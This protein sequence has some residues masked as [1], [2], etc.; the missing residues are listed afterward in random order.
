MPWQGVSAVDLRLQFIADVQT[1][2]FTITELAERYHVSRKTAYKWIALARQHGTARLHDASRRPQ[3]SPTRTPVAIVRRLCE[4]RQR[5]PHWSARKL[6]I[7]LRRQDPTTA[8]PCA[9][10]AH[11]WL[12]REGW[13][14]QKPRRRPPLYPPV[15]LTP[16]TRPNA[17]W[18][19]D[20]KG[21]LRLGAGGW[22]Y[23]L[24]LRDAASRFVLRCVALT[25]RATGVTQPQFERAFREFGL[26][27]RIRSDN[28]TP[29]ASPGLARLSRLAVW[30][31]RLGI[32]PERITPGRPDQNGAHEQF[33]RVLKRATALPPAASLRAQQRRFN[34]FVPEYNE[35]RPHDALAGDPPARHYVPST[36]PYP[37]RLPPLEYPAAWPTR[38]VSINGTFSWR[39][40]PIRLTEALAG[41]HIAFEEV[42]D[43]LWC[44]HFATVAIVRFDDRTRSLLPLGPC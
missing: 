32:V 4:A 20:F 8:W 9:A 29:F 39:D 1:G 30:W 24:T 12:A 34:H 7:L 2:L 11:V 25:S 44:I 36:R 14:R 37:P 35:L 3:H 16:P 43:G 19:T 13:I 26:P 23:P 31:M 15:Q 21:E 18:T 6:L 17:L 42:D 41:Q 33:H 5:F 10:T 27:D 38:R 22:C 28:G 40:Q